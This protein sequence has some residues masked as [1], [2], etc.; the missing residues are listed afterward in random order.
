MCH[1]FNLQVFGFIVAFN[2]TKPFK[3]DV[4]HSISV[5]VKEEQLQQHCAQSFTGLVKV[6]VAEQL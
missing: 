1:C 4:Q 5:V 3:V 6:Y 2:Y